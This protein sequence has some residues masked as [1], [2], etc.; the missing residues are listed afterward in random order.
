MA[1]LEIITT[2]IALA[3]SITS[4]D[5]YVFFWMIVSVVIFMSIGLA[6]MYSIFFGIVLGMGIFV[7]FSTLLSPEFQTPETLSLISETFAQI[8]IGSSVY[9]IFILAILVPVNG[10]VS[11]TLPKNIG[12]KIFQTFFLSFLLIF[13][14]LAV[15][16]G[17]IEKNY[18]F[19]HTESAFVLIKRFMFYEELQNSLLFSF[20]F[21][22]LPTI[23]IF[24]IVFII[25]KMLFADIITGL[26][27]SIIENTKKHTKD[28]GGIGQD[29]SD[30][31]E[32]YDD[33]AVNEH[34]IIHGGHGH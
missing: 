13:F 14:L 25:Y 18:I 21:S 24:S 12:G 23:I 30:H 8:I 7:L 2:Q 33:G 5:V 6:R 27:M 9:L 31:H 17:L 22:H 26:I 20:I 34:E 1:Q 15:L 29:I 19:F 3:L 32:E 16:L 11:I 4:L 10:G 28:K